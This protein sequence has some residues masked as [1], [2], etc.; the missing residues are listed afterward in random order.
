GKPLDTDSDERPDA[1]ASAG[2]LLAGF[3]THQMGANPVLDTLTLDLDDTGGTIDPRLEGGRYFGTKKRVSASVAYIPGADTSE[4]SVEVSWQFILAQL[5]RSSL[6]LELRWGDRRTGAAEFLY[7]LRVN[8]GWS[9][10][11]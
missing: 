11:R 4:N 3:L 7:N 10:V 8:K 9:W 2:T 5:R 6:R 1:L